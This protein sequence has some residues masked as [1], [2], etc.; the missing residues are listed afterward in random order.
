[1]NFIRSEGLKH[2]Q[3]QSFL[4]SINSEHEDIPYFTEVRWLSRGEMLRKAYALQTEMKIFLLEK[5]YP[6]DHFGDHDFI[7]DFAF[8]VDM[9][10]KLNTLNTKLQGQDMLFFDQ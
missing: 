10:D 9:T 5:N 1:M 4:T 8:L 3:F 7:N 6:I 2:R